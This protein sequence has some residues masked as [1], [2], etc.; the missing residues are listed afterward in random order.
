MTPLRC[1]RSGRSNLW[2]LRKLLGGSI[3]HKYANGNDPIEINNGGGIRFLNATD[4]TLLDRFGGP[5]R[6]RKSRPPT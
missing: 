3:T 1:T 2:A 6:C 5:E 4:A